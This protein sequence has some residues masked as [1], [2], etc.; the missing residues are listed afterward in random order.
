MVTAAEHKAV[1]DRV[2]KL[3]ESFELF[4][5]KCQLENK[6]LIEEN[7]VLKEKL[8]ELEVKQN[9]LSTGST[10]SN[11][12]P[13]FSSLFVNGSKTNKLETN[14]TNV[15]NAVAMENDEIKKRERNLVVFGLPESDKADE[16]KESD[17]KNK[18]DEL[19][20]IMNVESSK[21]KRIVRFKR[22]ATDK[23]GVVLVE[24]K[25]KDDRLNI[26]KAAKKLK[27]LE[28]YKNV[29]FNF[30]LTSAQKSLSKQLIA[31]RNRMNGELASENFYYGIR[32]NKLVKIQKKNDN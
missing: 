22:G 31:E 1:C 4:K 21:I 12:K 11:V 27:D 28:N 8:K 16:E 29:Y 3:E 23:P 26:I 32:S 18:I 14:E 5:K 19:L 13:I 7:A 20:K 9:M 10:G 2:A 6:Q 15:L 30:D 24:L 25:N 17:D